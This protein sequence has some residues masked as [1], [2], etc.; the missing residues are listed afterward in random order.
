MQD[1]KLKGGLIKIRAV[2]ATVMSIVATMF[3]MIIVYLPL[4]LFLIIRRSRYDRPVYTIPPPCTIEHHKCF[5]CESY[6]GGVFG[7]GPLENFRSNKA[8]RC[9]HDW[10]EI[11]KADFITG[12]LEPI[13]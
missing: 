11:T 5:L 3:F 10:Q 7:K 2:L 8:K 4:Y 12:V 6:V 9:I 13:L 1:G